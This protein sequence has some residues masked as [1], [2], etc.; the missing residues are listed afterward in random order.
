MIRP[1]LAIARFG[2]AAN[3]RA[4]LTRVG[5][6]LVPIGALFGLLSSRAS[7]GHWTGQHAFLFYGYLMGAVFAVRS[8]LGEQR[9]NGLDTFLR[10]NLV[11]PLTHTLGATASVIGMWAILTTLTFLVAAVFSGGPADAGWLTWSYGLR[12]AMLLPF[13]LLVESVSALSIPLFLPAA[14]WF[15]A[16][17]VLTIV[18]G[19]DRAVAVL[20]PPVELGDWGSTLPIAAR[21]AVV[22][23]AGFALVLGGSVLG[24]ARGRS[25]ARERA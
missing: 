19:E 12:V 10:V 14:A 2:I 6:A 13:V 24:T 9:A 11:S 23:V 3:L 4:P 22:M 5:L 20:S 18:L 8:G 15:V 16:F 7:G 17:A 25:R 1:A 21:T